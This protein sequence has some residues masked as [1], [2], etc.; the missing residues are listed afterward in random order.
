MA[1]WIGLRAPN[2]GGLGSIHG[3]GTSMP[4]LR[5]RMPQLRNLPAATKTWCNQ[6]NKYLNKNKNKLFNQNFVPCKTVVVDLGMH[7][8]MPFKERHAAQLQGVGSADTL[9]VQ[10]AALSEVRPYLGW[11]ATSDC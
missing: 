9:Q 7:C 3:Q 5:V 2:A 6:I 10:R 8:Q 11:P 4:Q 1:Q